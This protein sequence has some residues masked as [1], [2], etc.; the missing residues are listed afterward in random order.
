MCTMHVPYPAYVFLYWAC[1]SVVDLRFSMRTCSR[2]INSAIYGNYSVGS[3][4]QSQRW[5][6]PVPPAMLPMQVHVYGMY[7]I[8]CTYIY[9]CR[10]LLYPY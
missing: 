7:Y 9:V 4:Q 1:I 6:F 10:S 3:G 2:T 8:I 5:T